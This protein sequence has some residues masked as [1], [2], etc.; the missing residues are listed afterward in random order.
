MLFGCWCILLGHPALFAFA[1]IPMSVG[2][3]QMYTHLSG[4]IVIDPDEPGPGGGTACREMR[5]EC[6]QIHRLRVESLCRLAAWAP[7]RKDWSCNSSRGFR[8]RK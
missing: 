1:W 6:I 3:D 5:A 2:P 8:G 4:F 7:D